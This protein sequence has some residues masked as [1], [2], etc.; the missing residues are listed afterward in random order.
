MPLVAPGVCRFSIV[1]Q[2]LGELCVNIVDVDIDAGVGTT[3]NE[4]IFGVAGD[5][6]NN[7]TDHVMPLLSTTYVAFQVRWVD[8]NSAEGT[9]GSRSSTDAEV[10]PALGGVGSPPLPASV[11]ARAYK[12]LVDRV[13]GERQ[14]MMRIGGLNEINTDAGNGNLLS[15]GFVEDLTNGLEAFK[16]GV[17]GG[18]VGGSI[19]IVVVHTVAGVYSSHTVLEEYVV[20][21]LVGS[22]RRRMP[23]YGD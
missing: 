19:N 17:N 3:R 15:N 21:N 20:T 23:G 11:Y 22:L 16:D 4:A 10:W 13:R 14:G 8:L 2:N 6:L 5:I 18:S 1:A 12:R 9:V 7:W